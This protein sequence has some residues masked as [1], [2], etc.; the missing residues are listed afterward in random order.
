MLLIAT[1]LT[2]IIAPATANPQ[3]EPVA[4][5]SNDKNIFVQ[6]EG[7]IATNNDIDQIL[8]NY[9]DQGNWLSGVA[10]G[11]NAYAASGNSGAA[12]SGATSLV[13]GGSGETMGQ[14]EASSN[15]NAATIEQISGAD[16]TA[17][18][19][20]GIAGP[21]LQENNLV[22]TAMAYIQNEQVLIQPV[23]IR[24]SQTANALSPATQE[25]IDSIFNENDWEK[26]VSKYIN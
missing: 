12:N 5:A 24:E 14:S 26:V 1:T 25:I 21:V 15:N 20:T 2:G 17:G 8:N 16:A 10:V 4:L 22:Q 19:P 7:A 13:G 18:S 11:G 6:V 9:G 3:V 23:S